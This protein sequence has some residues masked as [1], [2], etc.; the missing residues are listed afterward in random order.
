MH[1]SQYKEYMMDYIDLGIGANNEPSDL[2]D[3][4]WRDLWWNLIAMVD[5]ERAIADYNTVSTYDPEAGESKAHTYHW[6]HTLNALGHVQT[7]TGDLT[8]NYP[9]AMAFKKN[10]TMNYLAYNFSDSA[11]TVSY[12]N[13]K[14]M[15]VE[16]NNFKL[17]SN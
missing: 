15:T 8:A 3:D 13:G 14:T 4:L 9:A 6:I 5:P 17:E 7:G 16:P 11:I 12:S 2:G 1:V 10:G